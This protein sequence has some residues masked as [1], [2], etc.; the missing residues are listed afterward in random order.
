MTAAQRRRRED[1]RRRFTQRITRAHI[2]RDLF[3]P[4]ADH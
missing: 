1:N 2:R 3:V 4:M